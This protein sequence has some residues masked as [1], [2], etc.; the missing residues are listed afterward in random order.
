MRIR[1]LLVLSLV[2]FIQTAAFSQLEIIC[3]QDTSIRLPVGCEATVR[4]ISPLM[5]PDS[6]ALSSLR[7]ELSGSTTAS[8]TLDASGRRFNVGFTT[9]TYTVIDTSGM[10][11]SCTFTVH[12]YEERPPTFSCPRSVLNELPEGDTS[13]VVNNIALRDVADN[14]TEVPIVTYR[15]SGA[16]EGTGE[17][18]ASGTTFFEGITTVTYVVADSSGNRDSCSFTVAFLDEVI[19]LECPEDVSGFIPTDTCK[20]AIEDVPLTIVDGEELVNRVTYTSRGATTLISPNAGIND[21]SGSLFNPGQTIVTYVARDTNN[22]T[23]FCEFVVNIQ[24]TIPPEIICPN[25]TT[26]QVLEGATTFMLDTIPP[27]MAVDLCDNN[28]TLSYTLSGVTTGSGDGILMDSILALGVTTVEYTATDRFGNSASCSFDITIRPFQLGV[29][30]PRNVTLVTPLNSCTAVATETTPQIFPSLAQVSAVRFVLTGA[31]ELSSP[32]F[33]GK[34]FIDGE[35]INLGITEATYTVI[36][37]N[38]DTMA[39]CVFRITVRD[40]LAPVISNCPDSIR[41]PGSVGMCEAVATWDEPTAFES[42]GISFTSNFEPGDTFPAGLTDVIYT[43]VDSSGNTATCS[44]TVRVEDGTPPEISNCPDDII[45]TL[46]APTICEGPIVWIEPDVI[47]ACGAFRLTSTHQPGDIFRV[48]TTTVTYTAQDSSGNRVSC[49]FDVTIV[50]PFDPV[51]TN[52]PTDI[53]IN[54]SAGCA[55]TASWI[56]PVLND[57]CGAM[58][59]SNFEP[60]DTFPVGVTTVIYMATDSSGNTGSCSF[61]VTVENEEIPALSCPNDIELMVQGTCDTIVNWIEPVISSTC[62]TFTLT[63]THNPGDRFEV[64]T[65]TVEYT[66]TN[67]AG[68]ENTC[69]FDITIGREASVGFCTSNVTVNT[70]PGQCSATVTWNEPTFVGSCD[71]LTIIRTHA[72]GEEFPVGVT[73]VTYTAINENGDNLECSFE[74][75]VL[76]NESPVFT[77]CLRDTTISV[78]P[79]GCTAIYS[80][81]EPTVQDN[82]SNRP[83]LTSSHSPGFSFPLGTTRVTYTAQDGAGNTSTCSFNVTVVDRIPPNI[84]CFTG[85]EVRV[86]GE[87]ISDP[88][89][90]VASAQVDNCQN[91]RI[92]FRTPTATDGCSNPVTIQQFDNTGLQ[93]GSAFPLGLT[94]LQYR[95]T[96]AAGNSST[97]QFPVNVLPLE[98]VHISASE[99]R[100]CSGSSISLSAAEVDAPTAFYRWTG[101]NNFTAQGQVISLPNITLNQAGL[102]QVSVNT[103]TGCNLLGQISIEVLP[104]PDVTILHNDISCTDGNSNLQ[105]ELR[106]NNNI[107]LSSY[108]WS[109]PNNFQSQVSRPTIPNVTQAN[110]GTY[111]VIVVSNQGCVGRAMEVVEVIGQPERPTLTLLPVGGGCV[112]DTIS[113][114]GSS[115]ATAGLQYNWG[116]DPAQGVTL[117][118]STFNSN[119]ASFTA[120]G[121]YTF[122]YWVNV[123]NCA[124]DTVRAAI[125]VESQPELDLS[126]SGDTSC[127]NGTGSIQLFENRGDAVQ[128]LWEG[129]EGFASFLQNPIINNFNTENN[130]T[131][132]VTAETTNG[133]ISRDSIIINAMAAPTPPDIV[134]ASSACIG[135]TIVLRALGVYN[136]SVQYVWESPQGAI[137]GLPASTTAPEL[138]LLADSLRSFEI[139]AFVRSQNCVSFSDTLTFD[140][141][142]RPAI[143]ISETQDTYNCITGDTTMLLV[144]SGGDAV[145]WSWT[146]PNAFFSDM[147]EAGVHV[148]FDSTFLY[149][150]PYYLTVRDTNGCVSSDSIDIAVS[151]GIRQLTVTGASVF[152]DGDTLRLMAVGD[153]PLDA[154]YEWEGP[155]GYQ[156]F[157][158]SITIPDV[159]PELTGTYRV[160]GVLADCSSPL[161][162]PF[163]VTVVARPEL[164]PDKFNVILGQEVTLDILAND[165]IPADSLVMISLKAPPFQGSAVLNADGTVTYTPAV[166]VLAKDNFSY[167]I[168]YTVCQNPA[169]PLCDEAI[170]VLELNYPPDECVIATIITPN[171]DLKNDKFIISCIAAG[172]YPNNELVIFNQWGNQVFEAKPYLNDW[173]GTYKGEGLPD[174]TYYYIFTPEP[175]AEARKGFI[176]IYR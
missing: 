114:L 98:E 37:L 68:D 150:G 63:S 57:A 49:S 99:V 47:D 148:Q 69:S 107:P 40:T 159:Y 112:G 21:V 25:D 59:T 104:T 119:K 157:T 160:R 17:G 71:N 43:A 167:Q 33:G 27:L 18:D 61:T 15:L 147:Q 103:T 9:V 102:Y 173:D 89:N 100:P 164:T 130:G 149:Q 171:G 93:S 154:T 162:S 19:E 117:G 86:D 79:G 134:L 113:L 133:C 127:V 96:D 32:A 65:T 6:A 124:S 11:A 110:G 126:Y 67:E 72:P 28:P 53:T 29:V 48:G 85:I 62:G 95:A 14:C 94:T 83:T 101:P 42:C 44:F 90:V 137:L 88:S 121:T 46:I 13:A 78:I 138:T 92:N 84:Q 108:V 5:L 161:S 31:T 172:S 23:F 54:A 91:V 39:S 4:A 52:C 82:C 22:M 169:K 51:F 106:N 58:V 55:A 24:D 73:E 70:D 74:V 56:P 145:E 166:D 141:A 129:P 143:D 125:F 168:C 80:W 116:V 163:M 8:D 151:R 132:I 16:T 109:G 111:R 26:F 64:G 144:E 153:M 176:T 38:R 105:L 142:R 146:G 136:D 97:C 158:R 2:L 118:T 131:Y 41:V 75:E 10:E 135:D 120:G 60:G 34:Y 170:V 7:F 3:P 30:C 76:D 12:V 50:D 156:A 140:I 139:V 175:G 35:M 123:G 20:L 115:Y 152:C 1:Q 81:F 77:E 87:I 36:S 128:W 45:Q 122:K 174:G 155:N 165:T 66:V